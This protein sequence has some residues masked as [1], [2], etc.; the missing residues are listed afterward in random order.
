MYGLYDK[1]NDE[2]YVMSKIEVWEYLK[3]NIS[4]Y[5]Q[6]YSILTDGEMV[7]IYEPSMGANGKLGDVSI[8]EF[9]RGFGENEDNAI[10]I[11]PI[12]KI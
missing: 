5:F 7:K 12:S 11:R 10:I 1:N 8:D 4:D 9:F 6:N 3:N 2:I